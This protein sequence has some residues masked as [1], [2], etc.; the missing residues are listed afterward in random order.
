MD[1]VMRESERLNETIKS[2]LAYARPQRQSAA[3]LDLR[4]AV[5]DTTT[6]LQNS[7]ELQQTH[8]LQLNVPDEPVWCT[9]DEGQ[10]RQIVWN[11]ATNGLR[12]M[13]D[14]GLLTLTVSAVAAEGDATGEALIVVADEGVGIPSDQLEGILQ[15]FRGGFS[16]GT[17]LGLSIVHRIVSDYGG[18]LQVTSQPNH[19]TSVTV[20]LPLD[21][22][23]AA[24]AR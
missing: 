12:A 13:P 14:G 23:L 16:R 2:F 8:D 3:R 6:L 10:I 21:G 24:M 4:K 1:I 18:E 11:L 22:Q 15:P 17:G 20:R 9:A 5:T 7:P 19:G